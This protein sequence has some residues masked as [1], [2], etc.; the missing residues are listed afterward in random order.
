ME[1]E[2][3][4]LIKDMDKV[5]ELIRTYRDS[6]K[7]IVQDYIYSDVLTAIRKRKIE[8]DG[9]IN[10]IYTVKTGRKGIS[11]NE[12]EQEISEEVYN[13]LKI[14]ERRATIIKDRYV[15][16]YINDLKIE[17]DIFH[18]E[19]ESVVFAEI[20]FIDEE[21]AMNTQVPNWFYR[22]IGNEVSNSKMSRREVDVKK[23]INF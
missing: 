22:E 17:L 13:S 6:K 10:Y 8:K 23:L 5:N 9:H 20:E 1:I 7:T 15:I 16:P 4:F 3:R 14:D 2:R 11:V 18:G 12:F 19:Y 21:Q